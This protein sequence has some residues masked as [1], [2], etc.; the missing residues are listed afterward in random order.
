MFA[1][2]LL[3]TA[4]LMWATAP[5]GEF[6]RNT[7]LRAGLVLGALWLAYP[8]L[9]ELFARF[10]PSTIFGTLALLMVLIIRPKAVVYLLPLVAVLL[11][12]KFLRWLLR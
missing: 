2:G 9:V 7:C 10:S 3:A 12:L 4:L 5:A 1:L 6:V 8:Q 11:V